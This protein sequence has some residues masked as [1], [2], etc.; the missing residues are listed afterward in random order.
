[1]FEG[2]VGE[3]SNRWHETEAGGAMIDDRLSNALGIV[4]R[5]VAM[6]HAV[7]LSDRALLETFVRTKDGSAFGTLLHRHGS[8]VL[9][10]CRRVLKHSHD[11][12]DA[13][14]A[15]FLIL[16][17]KA[18]TIR[19]RDSLAAWLHGVACRVAQ[20]LRRDLAR[21]APPHHARSGR[22]ARRHDRGRHLA[23]R[24]GASS[25]KSC[26]G[27]PTAIALRWCFA[28]WKGK[29][30]T[31]RPGSS[32][33]PIPSCAAGWTEVVSVCAGGCCAEG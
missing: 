31:R 7:V 21:R 28:I 4:Q 27:C 16:A 15:T 17:Q 25:T 33:G 3:L 29:P 24:A 22:G 11:A 6:Q 30:R 20:R 1:M 26:S 9:G 10:T 5:Q 19:Q 32:V 14:Q 23:R 18:G 12:E 2:P 8:M 13:C